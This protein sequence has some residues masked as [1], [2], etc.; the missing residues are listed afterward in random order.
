[1]RTPKILERLQEAKSRAAVVLDRI[2]QQ[3][4]AR[5]ELKE[6]V[7]SLKDEE[8]L[9]THVEEVLLRLSN[10]V[11]ASSTQTLEN[12]TTTGLRLVFDD[13]SLEVK[14][15]I[16]RYRGKTAVKFHLYEDGKTA[17]MMDSYGG[18]ILVMIG[19]LTRVTTIMALGS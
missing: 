5:D 15:E 18:G 6:R 14:T 19:V 12:L 1:M 7:R 13:Q 2:G 3:E 11:L 4:R 16:D 9:L 8:L 10:L 17:P